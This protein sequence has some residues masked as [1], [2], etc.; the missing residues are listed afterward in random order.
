M[1]SE[2]AGPARPGGSRAQIVALLIVS[3]ALIAAVLAV[4]VHF[5]TRG[6]ADPNGLDMTASTNAAV[7]EPPTPS[8]TGPTPDQPGPRFTFFSAETEVHCPPGGDGPEL[9]VS[10]ETADAAQ[11]WFAVG[12]EDT[13]DEDFVPVAAN[14]TQADLPDPNPFPCGQREYVDYTMMLEGPNGERATETF[15]VIDLNWAGGEN[16]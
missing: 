15:R 2:D 3:G 13:L 10:W 11:V 6:A 5:V 14:G 8:P 7:L 12:D 16:H 9:R 1:T 4:L